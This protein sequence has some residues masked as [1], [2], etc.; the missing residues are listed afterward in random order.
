[1]KILRQ[2]SILILVVVS[3]PAIASA[4]TTTAI[5]SPES[6]SASCRVPIASSWTMASSWTICSTWRRSPT[7]SR[8]A[9]WVSHHSAAPCMLRSSAHPRTW[10]RLDELREINR[11]LAHRSGDPGGGAGEPGA[12]RSRLRDGDP[13]HALRRGRTEPEPADLS[14][15]AWRPP[16]TRRSSPSSTT[17]C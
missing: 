16:T 7:G 12:R 2:L 11:R 15:I 17:S 9:R 14:L 3:V 13:V 8:C 10:Q 1:M 5:P 4:Q 6:V